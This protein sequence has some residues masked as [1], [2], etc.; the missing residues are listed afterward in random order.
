MRQAGRKV[1]VNVKARVAVTLWVLRRRLA[2]PVVAH[3]V[4]ALGQ[5]V[6]V[7]VVEVFQNVANLL[8]DADLAVLGVGV[9]GKW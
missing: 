9:G 4:A 5:V 7:R 3:L 8:A 6:R 1:A 2:V